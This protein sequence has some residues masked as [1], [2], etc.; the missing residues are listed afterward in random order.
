MKN[1]FKVKRGR[2]WHIVHETKTGFARTNAWTLCGQHYDEGERTARQ[3]T[4]PSCLQIDNP[5]NFTGDM[6]R[7][8]TDVIRIPGWKDAPKNEAYQKLIQADIITPQLKLTRRG[9][10]LA[11]DFTEAPVPLPDDHNV[12]H[13]RGPLSFR[14][15]CRGALDPEFTQIEGM[16]VDRYAKLRAASEGALVTCLQCLSK[17][18]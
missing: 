11:E 3:P 18:D 7:F 1:S 5:R 17:E 10:I 9:S 2:V 13:A 8:I 12:M 16:T 6:R 4:C 15:K 14:P